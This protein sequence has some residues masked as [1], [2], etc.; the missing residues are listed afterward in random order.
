[1]IV[2]FEGKSNRYIHF[3]HESLIGK[4]K[5][6]IFGI[7]KY[8]IFRSEERSQGSCEYFCEIWEK[9]KIAIK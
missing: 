8:I 5:C 1:M 4:S 7:I 3:Y 2:R 6:V 9:K